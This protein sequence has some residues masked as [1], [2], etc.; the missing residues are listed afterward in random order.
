[1]TCE[2]LIASGGLG[3]RMPDSMNPKHNKSL[4]EY[5][6]QPLIG[7]LIDSLKEGG[8]NKFVFSSGYH[9]FEEI[10]NI[11][12]SKNINAIVVPYHGEFRYVPWMWKDLLGE[13]FLFVCGHHPLTA[14]FVDNLIEASNKADSVIT[15]Y[16]NSKYPIQ[17]EHKILFEGKLDNP[18]LKPV[19]TQEE[20]VDPSHKYVRNPY[21]IK[22]K[23]LNLAKAEK[24]KYTFSYYIYQ[25]W[26]N[27]GSLIVLDPN[28]PPEFDY[29]DEF[30]LTK[31]FLD[32]VI[33]E[34]NL[35]EKYQVFSKPYSQVNFNK[36]TF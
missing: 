18:N 8:I 31:L 5:A 20:D 11:V 12:R 7:H 3:T 30:Q 19:N 16:D 26:K 22:K 21:V 6:G 25:E 4:I 9:N 29:E 17:K 1:M 27:G 14:R 15:A 2:A 13:Q 33:N 32:K 28:I 34:K 36:T 35:S 10:K 23:I 24:F